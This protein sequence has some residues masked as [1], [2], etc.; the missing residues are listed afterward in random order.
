LAKRGSNID[1]LGGYKSRVENWVL[2]IAEKL[3]DVI[4]LGVTLAGLTP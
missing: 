3:P 4:D 1:H 2:E